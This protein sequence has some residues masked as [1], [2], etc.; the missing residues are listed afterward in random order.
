MHP[1]ACYVVMFF[2]LFSGDKLFG[3]IRNGYERQRFGNMVNLHTLK[4]RLAKTKRMSPA[5]R[6]SLR[7]EIND[8]VNFILL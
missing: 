4:T 5:E 8:A 3:K 1:Y 7:Y 6:H 2:A